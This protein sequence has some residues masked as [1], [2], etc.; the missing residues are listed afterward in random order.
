M[1][2]K[3]LFCG[4]RRMVSVPMGSIRCGKY[5]RSVCIECSEHQDHP[6]LNSWRLPDRRYIPHAPRTF[7][8]W[9][10]LAAISTGITVGIIL[11]HGKR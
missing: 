1:G 8:L 4:S 9:H 11:A 5:I 2:K 10:T 3:C 7:N 6:P